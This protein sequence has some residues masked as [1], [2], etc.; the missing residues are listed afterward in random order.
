MT[1][2]SI[3][4]ILIVGGGVCGL[5]VGWRLAQAGRPVTV[6]ERREIGPD[7]LPAATWASA[8]MLAPHIEAEPGEEKL[9]PLLLESHARWPAFAR[10]LQEAS[11]VDVGYRTE[12]TLVVAL[13]RD[14]AERLRFQ[15]EFQRSLGLELVW[16]S[17]DAARQREPHLSRHVVAALYSPHDHQVDNRQALLALRQAFLAAGGVLRERATVAEILVGNGEVQG[18]RLASGETLHA[19]VVVIAAGAWSATLPGLPPEAQ[20][21]VRPVKG[22]MLALQTPPNAPL[23]RHVVWGRDVYLVP[24]KDGRLLVGATVEEKGFDAQLTAGGVYQLL[25]RAWELLPGIDEAP[26]IE[27]WAG[28]RPGSRDD[29]PILGATSVKGLILATGHY[30]NGILLA[31]ITADAVSHLI[32]TGETPESIRSF[33]IE[34]FHR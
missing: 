3:D 25:R 26:L 7:S 11:G 8:G 14:Q 9:L 30:R 27:L 13:D 22:Q 32:L 5:G 23:L 31:P 2:Q 17:G 34:R 28:L 16:L 18:V 4:S 1:K 29:A 33:G 12:G 20:P 21:P 24:R 10:E 19:P 6:L 15:Y